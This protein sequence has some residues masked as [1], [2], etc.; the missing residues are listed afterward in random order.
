ML[1]LNFKSNHADVAIINEK[2][3]A[4]PCLSH[5][6]NFHE[7]VQVSIKHTLGV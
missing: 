3:S 6:E 5:E 7:V 1:V 4:L 2:N